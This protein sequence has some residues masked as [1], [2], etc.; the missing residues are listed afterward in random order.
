[1]P[2]GIN[3]I[4]NRKTNLNFLADSVGVVGADGSGNMYLV[5]VFC[6]FPL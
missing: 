4:A 2:R 5:H 6:V 1:M 3:N